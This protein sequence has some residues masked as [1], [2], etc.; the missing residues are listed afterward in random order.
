MSS[1][2]Q[3]LAALLKSNTAWAAGVQERDPDFFTNSAK[4]PQ[5]PK[6]LW[7]GCSDSRV[8]ESVVLA[9]KPGDV[10]VHRNIGN[11][12]KLDDDSAQAVL[13]YSIGHLNVRH[14][15]VVGHTNCGAC[16]AT[17]DFTSSGKDIPVN[18]ITRFLN[19]LIDIAKSIE[20]KSGAE[21]V[22]A[23]VE[24]N[25]KHQV[26]NVSQSSVVKNTPGVYVHG[27]VY[28]LETGTFKD[29]GVTFE[30]K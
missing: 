4:G 28:Q 15:L 26:K 17:H 13:D 14:V 21:A 18:S 16:A 3:I 22:Q 2:H 5:E 10:F 30:S 6:V 8:P 9:T 20:G 11:Q 24:A 19:E 12:F 23:I 1:D 27:W 25:V 7:L 29:L